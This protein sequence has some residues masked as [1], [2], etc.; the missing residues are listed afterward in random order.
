MGWVILFTIGGLGFQVKTP[1]VCIVSVVLWGFVVSFCVVHGALVRNILKKSRILVCVRRSRG[2]V[3]LMVL[4][5]V[6]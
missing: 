1:H 3:I 6:L 4:T 2:V 5:M